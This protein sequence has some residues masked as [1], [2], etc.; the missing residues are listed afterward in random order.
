MSLGQLG[1]VIPVHGSIRPVLP[2]LESLRGDQAPA[3][4]RPA[5]VIVV[6]DATPVPVAAD[7]LPVG[8]ELIRRE[9]NGGFGAA[10][11]T[12]LAALAETV[13][14]DEP[15]AHEAPAHG[16]E[17]GRIEHALVLNSDLE[18]PRGFC[19]RL[20]EH[21]RPW[22]PA[23]VGCRNVGESG[24]SGYAARRF[25]T[26]GH[27]VTEW[28][29]PLASQRHRDLLHR[30]VGHDLD[31]E[32]GTGMIPVDWVSGAVLLLPLAEVRGAG[33]FD[34]GYFMYTE[35]VD[36]QLRLRREGIPSLLDAD[37]EVRH[38]GGA[39]SGG[40]ARR[41]GWLVGARMR[42]ARKHSSVH[43]LRAGMSLATGVN[44]VWNAGRR[45]AGRDVH[46]LAVAREELHLIHRS[47]RELPR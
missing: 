3:A 8:T 2:L 45:A 7:D 5:R 9:T 27:Q 32:R 47:G 16:V 43:L 18:I 15:F 17:R 31:A 30:A 10:V 12:G 40:E 21:A 6:D 33:G 34:E 14:A 24:G 39:S 26:I 20:V 13:L 28:L 19:R 25:P 35:E 38:V 23:V 4:D 29:V 11:N 1:V 36:L 44:L 22:M 42:Y 46:P 37:L 41:R